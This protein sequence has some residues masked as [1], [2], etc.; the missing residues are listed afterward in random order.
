M[1][2]KLDERHFIEMINNRDTRRQKHPF[3]VSTCEGHCK[4][5]VFFFVYAK[6]KAQ[7]LEQ[8]SGNRA[9]QPQK[10]A[11]ALKFQI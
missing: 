6:T 3:K 2:P 5:T 1:V 7:K 11:R 10:M 8:L 4:K 9:V